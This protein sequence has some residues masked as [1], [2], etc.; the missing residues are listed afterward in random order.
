M[1]DAGARRFG[2]ALPD[3]RTLCGVTAPDALA[4][5]VAAL[6]PRFRNLCAPRHWA[7]LPYELHRDGAELALTVRDEEFR[8]PHVATGRLSGLAHLAGRYWAATLS[9]ERFSQHPV[10]LRSFP[11]A[12]LEAELRPQLTDAAV[13]LDMAGETLEARLCLFRAVHGS[14]FEGRRTGPTA[15]PAVAQSLLEAVLAPLAVEARLA[16]QVTWRVHRALPLAVDYFADPDPRER[17]I[18][19]VV[20]ADLIREV[21]NTSAVAIAAV[22]GGPLVELCSDPEPYVR[23]CAALALARLADL[24]WLR[25]AYRPLERVV[26]ACLEQGVNIPEQLRRRWLCRLAA[27][28]DG[29]DGD[30]SRLTALGEHGVRLS[31]DGTLV[32]YGDLTDFRHLGTIRAA[33]ANLAWARGE[34]LCRD[35]PAVP[36]PPPDR[37]TVHRDRARALLAMVAP[38]VTARVNADLRTAWGTVGG[39]LRQ[40]LPTSLS[41]SSVRDYYA[42]LYQASGELCELTGD[43]D[44]ALAMHGHARD[45]GAAKGDR[46]YSTVDLRR[47]RRRRYGIEA[48][49][50]PPADFDPDW[51]SAAGHTG[52]EVARAVAVWS[53]RHWMVAPR[54]PAG[55]P[56][57]PLAAVLLRAL[58]RPAFWEP[59]IR[60]ERIPR[61]V[62][63]DRF[64]PIA[65]RGEDRLVVQWEAALQP[66][67]VLDVAFAADV[68][69]GGWLDSLADIEATETALLATLPPAAFHR[70]AERLDALGGKLDLERYCVERVHEATGSGE[71]VRRYLRL[72]RAARDERLRWPDRVREVA[73]PLARAVWR[74]IEESR[75]GRPDGH[76]DDRL[77]RLVAYGWHPVLARPLR[78][79][80]DGRPVPSDAPAG[81]DRARRLRTLRRLVS[82]LPTSS[83]PA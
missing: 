55:A 62:L 54:D 30:W 32:N 21:V 9:D 26:S 65:L 17:A 8:A 82:L 56:G 16:R 46:A 60:G 23:E 48:D 14:R 10:W 80:V 19:A 59:A 73:E 63:Y 77:L 83:P 78:D 37:A 5:C 61:P 68:D 4:E 43:V 33:R 57:T 15:R 34:D 67:G 39:R 53:R 71:T 2:E 74:T 72:L 44:G 27:G 6:L 81:T 28:D 35:E 13:A 58:D 3:A 24:L 47:L 11:V 29:A 69:L 18:A 49:P 25:Q 36:P 7:V 79:L 41:D 22:A 20:V 64:A 75:R 76:V 40:G 52:E 70:L 12:V 42:E 1:R 50:D 51:L 31:L 45:I 66:D 38:E